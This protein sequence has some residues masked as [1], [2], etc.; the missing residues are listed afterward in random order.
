MKAIILAAGLSKRMG[1]NKLLLEYNDGTILT[2]VIKTVLNSFLSPTLITGYD[3]EKIEKIASTFSIHTLF[4]PSYLS[5]RK[6][7]ILTALNNFDDDLIFFPGDLPLIEEDEI[8][9]LI[10]Y[11]YANKVL[12]LRPKYKN[13]LG[14][15]VI[16]SSLLRPLLLENPSNLEKYTREE[17][18]TTVPGSKSTV[19][20]I[21]TKERY[22]ELLTINKP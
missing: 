16:I 4:N 1:E 20:D 11:F 10:S 15:P 6:T 12:C 18:V 9:N 5:G 22:K 21:D 14:H 8:K 2:S 13:E 19:F 3:R 7:S 17:G